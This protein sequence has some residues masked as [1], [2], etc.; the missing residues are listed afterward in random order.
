MVRFSLRE[1]VRHTGIIYYGLLNIERSKT[2]A[3]DVPATAIIFILYE[4]AL[5]LHHW[6]GHQILCTV[7]Y[8]LKKVRSLYS[9]GPTL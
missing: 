5:M 3:G 4:N 6:D 8:V 9:L 7:M 1:V 2:S